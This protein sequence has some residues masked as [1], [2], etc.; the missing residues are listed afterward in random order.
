MEERHPQI[1]VERL[2]L[3]YGSFVVMEDLSFV[4]ERGAIFFVMGGSGSGKSTVMRALIGLHQPSAGAIYYD[5][6][7]FL[8]QDELHRELTLRRLGVLYQSSG[9]FTSMTVAENVA[10][11]LGEFTELSPAEVREV[12]AVKLSLVGLAGFEDFYPG[13]LSGGMQKRAGLARAMALDP[14][15]LFLDEPS[16]GLDPISARRLDELIVELRDSLGTT[17]VIVSHELP[18]ILG[19]GDDSIFLDTTVRTISARGRPRELLA[20]PP[21]ERIREFL[22]RGDSLAVSEGGARG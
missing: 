20:H 1:T 13:E 12:V 3:A 10:L 22:T 8:Q 18:S 19:I 11:P 14:E 15:I 6:E 2:T 5:G 9:L 17:V 16:A 21:H 4:V 7:D